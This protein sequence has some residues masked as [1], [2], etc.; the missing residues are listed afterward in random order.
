M[1]VKDNSRVVPYEVTANATGLTGRAGLGLVAETAKAI[2]AD[3]ALSAAVG[4]SRSW[5]LHD[6]GKV[7]RDVALT[8]ADGGDALRHMKVIDGQ[9]ELFGPVASSA[10]ACRT[11]VAVAEDPQAMAALAAA[12]AVAR[13]RAWKLGAAPAAVRWRGARHLPRSPERARMSR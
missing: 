5:L 11:I 9:P 1:R 4:R 13:E 3:R 7:L 8:L 6:P 2:G 10:T 12:R